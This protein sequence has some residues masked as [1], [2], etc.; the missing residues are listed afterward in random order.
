MATDGLRER[1]KARRRA[2]I[3]R[4]AFELFAERGFDST[5]VA[6]VAEAAEVSPRTVTLYFRTKQDIALSR[7]TESADRLTEALRQRGPGERALDVMGR[8]LRAESAHRDEFGPLARRMLETNPELRALQTARMA[9]AVHEGVKAIARDTGRPVD[10]IGPLIAAA[11]AAAI[12]IQLGECSS[13]ET[14]E[15]HITTAL[16]FLEAGLNTL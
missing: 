1:G 6:D 2:A 5:T 11:A 7:F 9:A 12:I 10:D 15:E 14:S 13:G 8:W 4:A 16:T 3:T